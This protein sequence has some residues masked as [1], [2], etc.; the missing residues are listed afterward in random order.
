M[1]SP[2][3]YWYLLNFTSAIGHLILNLKGRND[4]VSFQGIRSLIQLVA[5]RLELFASASLRWCCQGRTKC[6]GRAAAINNTAY[7]MPH[8]PISAGCVWQDHPSWHSH[9]ASSWLHLQHSTPCF[10]WA[11]RFQELCGSGWNVF[12]VAYTYKPKIQMQ[13]FKYVKQSTCK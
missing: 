2:F 1:F 12:F 8:N 9:E 13:T 7:L 5:L 10:V 6:S 3:C 11:C 4:N